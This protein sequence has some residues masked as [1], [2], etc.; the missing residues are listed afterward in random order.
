MAAVVDEGIYDGA[1]CPLS[2]WP[3]SN[4]KAVRKE[5]KLIG[6]GGESLEECFRHKNYR[7]C[8]RWFCCQT[9]KRSRQHDKQKL[10]HMKR[11]LNDVK[12][13][14]LQYKLT[15]TSYVRVSTMEV[16]G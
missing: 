14:H 4:I 2:M 9:I 11:I 7:H 15:Q 10:C 12:Y 8:Q 1:S 6:E 3:R 16:N 5:L 13:N